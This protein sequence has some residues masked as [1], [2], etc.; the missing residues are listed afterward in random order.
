MVECG[1]IALTCIWRQRYLL[2]PY[3]GSLVFGGVDKA[4]YTGPLVKVPIENTTYFT[5]NG[6][7]FTSYE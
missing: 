5:S 7:N 3:E 2:L 6:Y 4:K 1:F